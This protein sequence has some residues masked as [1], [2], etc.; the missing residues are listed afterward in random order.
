MADKHLTIEQALT[1]L[2]ATSSRLAT[3]TADL[4]PARLRTRPTADD[5]S[6]NEVLAHLRACADMWG[7][8]IVAMLDEGM[9]TRRAINPRTWINQTNYLDLEFQPSLRDFAAQ[10]AGLLAHLKP[11]PPAGWARSV[12]VTGG[13]APLQRTV[14]HYAE[15]L[16]RHERPHIKQIERLASALRT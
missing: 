13:G 2:A 1:V 11:L 4:A 9:T 3:L 14:L 15:R 16:A 8:A 7:G 10:R 12:T 5:W 6:A